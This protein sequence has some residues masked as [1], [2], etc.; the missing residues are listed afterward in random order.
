MARWLSLGVVAWLVLDPLPGPGPADPPGVV[1]RQASR[2]TTVLVSAAVSLTEVLQTVARAYERGILE[3]G[4]GGERIVLNL[5]GS[6]T[7]ARQI[8]EGAPVDL[9][10]SAD[11]AQMDRVEQAGRIVAGS[12]VD[13]LSNQLVVI[14]P[15][16]RA[17]LFRSP[18]DLLDPEI[19]RI[20]VGDPAAVPAGVYAKQY[21]EAQGLW[22]QV[23]AK[24]V[25]M[26]SVRGTLS[27]VEAGNADAGIV[28]RTD[29]AIATRAIVALAVPVEDG[30]S[31]AYPAAVMVDAPNQAGARRFLAHLQGP[32]AAAVFE[33]AGFIVRE[34]RN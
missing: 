8:A 24:I 28:Y 6:N 12:R 30:P 29:A 26:M 34:T 18:R 22:P 11:A 27:A 32:D 31:I 15:D 7:L 23:R 21:L 17:R 2:G 13:L 4:E 5:A 1:A 14:V 25:P 20:A 33:R 19:G 9:F 16:D 3:R 10:I